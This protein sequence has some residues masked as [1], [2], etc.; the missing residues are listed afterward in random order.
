MSRHS[1]LIPAKKNPNNPYK[2]SAWTP[3]THSANT[4]MFADRRELVKKWFNNWSDK[5]KKL[6]IKDI[7]DN[8]D[9]KLH[10]HIH[11]EVKARHPFPEGIDF[12]RILPRNL[13]LKIFKYLKPSEL[14][15]ASL[16][17]HQWKEIAENEEIWFNF[18]RLNN[19][20][21]QKPA[22]KYERAV[23]K[24]L[25]SSMMFQTFQAANYYQP[26]GYNM[27][28]DQL[29]LLNNRF[30]NMN[31]RPGSSMGTM[32]PPNPFMVNNMQHP[33]LGFSN[34]QTFPSNR[35]PMIGQNPLTNSGMIAT[36]SN[37]ALLHQLNLQS[38][39]PRNNNNNNSARPGTASTLQPVALES[40]RSKISQNQNY[41]ETDR[42]S[43]ASRPSTKNSLRR[44]SRPVSRSGS[45]TRK[46]RVRDGSLDNRPAWKSNDKKALD[47][48]RKH[49][50][51]NESFL[52]NRPPTP[53]QYDAVQS[54]INTNNKLP[55]RPSSRNRVKKRA[56]TPK[57]N[58]TTSQQ[59]ENELAAPSNQTQNAQIPQNQPNILQINPSGGT[60]ENAHPGIPPFYPGNM[61]NGN[62][63]QAPV[64]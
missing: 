54:K 6:L 9:V 26:N 3:R 33:P 39:T 14:C 42:Q 51:L 64:V 37:Y 31:S 59:I 41:Q 55:S 38:M 47:T 46:G 12:T 52:S 24:R 4:A 23:W 19:W 22:S 20:N 58:L 61:Q 5:Q 13:S 62:L 11:Q 10:Q 27:T 63:V 43:R 2:M 34:N 29:M 32:S 56:E 17:S 36:S 30:Q 50:D 57:N 35:P 18:C 28:Q 21:L 1:E 44:S 48:R 40:S 49:Y 15:Q 7:L 25:Y 53:K 16:V 45:L 8:S 60:N